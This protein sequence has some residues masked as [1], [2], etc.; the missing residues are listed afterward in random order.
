MFFARCDCPVPYTTIKNHNW[1]NQ[2]LF[3]TCG[4]SVVTL[5]VKSQGLI[6]LVVG[7]C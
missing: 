6:E 7:E 5:R 4:L 2:A 3:M 1:E